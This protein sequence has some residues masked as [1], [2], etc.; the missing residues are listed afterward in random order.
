MAV[1]AYVLNGM[2]YESHR[3]PWFQFFFSAV[4]VDAARR[5]S[6]W[7][8]RGWRAAEWEGDDIWGGDK[9]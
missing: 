3:A 8:A 7:R 4:S 5:S 6:K 1:S 2:D 9:G